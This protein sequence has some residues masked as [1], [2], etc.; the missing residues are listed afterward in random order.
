MNDD[1]AKGAGVG[2]DFATNYDLMAPEL[3][4]D[5][6]GTIDEIVRRCPV[7][8]SPDGEGYWVFSAYDDVHAIARDWETFSNRD[9]FMPN[10][11]D[12]SDM[13]QWFPAEC[14]PPFHDELRAVLN[15]HLAPKAIAAHEPAIRKHIDEII[16]E[17]VGGDEVEIV[18]QFAN[19]VPARVFCS[20]IAGMPAEDMAFLQRCFHLGLLG[21]IDQRGK[22]LTEAQDYIAEYLTKRSE[23]PGRGDVVDALLA[24]ESPG[25]S[26]VQKAGTFSQL[27]GGGIGTTGFIFSGAL[28]HLATHPQDR[29]LLSE[30]PSKL[31]VAIEEFLR[32]YASAPQIARRAVADAEISGTQVAT[33]DRVVLSF[34]AANRD[35]DKFECP[36]EVDIGRSPNR[37][38]AFGAGVHRC[39]GTHLARA[40]IKNGLEAFL[41]RIPEFEVADDFRPE[42]QVGITREMVALPMRIKPV[43]VA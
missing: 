29:Q 35:P 22:V 4:E 32:F 6:D 10:R 2:R 16:D 34:G 36:A 25:Y 26:F 43:V 15:P 27:T 19:A 5:F 40:I 31:P 41:E 20:T 11:P 7:A 21:P 28:H 13:P 12:P 42:Y 3:H 14:D 9:G 33:G 37:H 17:F 1:G 38:V 23:E 18:R 8:H 24:F 30:D 39:I